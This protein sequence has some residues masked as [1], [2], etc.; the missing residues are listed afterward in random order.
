[1]AT[2]L[3]SDLQPGSGLR[4]VPYWRAAAMFTGPEALARARKT[5]IASSIITEHE[6]P[7]EARAAYKANRLDTAT[8]KGKVVR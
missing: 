4:P 2:Y 3:V 1:M 5:C 6:D 7:S 8:M